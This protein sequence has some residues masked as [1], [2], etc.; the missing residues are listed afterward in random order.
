MWL[1]SDFIA[2]LLKDYFN[3][4]Q[5]EIV[6][7]DV[8]PATGDGFAS[9]ILRANVIFSR[10]SECDMKNLSLIVKIPVLD[11]TVLAAK[12]ANNIYKKRD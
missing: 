8:G 4:Q 3:D 2:L 6:R 7:F 9:S 1:H 10:K 12:L 11:K 5:L